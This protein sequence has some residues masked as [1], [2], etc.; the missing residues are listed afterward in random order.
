MTELQES[1]QQLVGAW[2][3]FASAYQRGVIQDLDGVTAAF[4]GTVLP[5]LN[6]IALN[7]PVENTADLSSRI[8]A[9]VRFARQ[10]GVGYFI[11]V[12]EDWLAPDARAELEPLM[13][14]R[15]LV[16][17]MPWT[18]MAAEHLLSSSDAPEL[19]FH[20]TNTEAMRFAAMDL[21]CVS[22]D[23][24]VEVGRA[25]AGGDAFWN[26]M[27][28]VVGCVEG[29]PVTTATV[30]PVDGRLYVAM[31][32]THPDH[33][34]RGYAEACMRDALDR[35]GRATGFHRTILH[36]TNAGHPVYRRMGYHDTSRFTLFAEPH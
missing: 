27:F 11:S 13:Q 2:S 34:R 4:A 30:V 35:A 16:P 6:L 22:Y 17:V 5:F 12:C 7:R 8:E 19:E 25:A 31:V 28:G 29:T 36:A 23:T 26:Q 18:G 32:A 3:C 24:P 9:A 14:D 15:G 10:Q 1:N 21:N 20:A 33:R